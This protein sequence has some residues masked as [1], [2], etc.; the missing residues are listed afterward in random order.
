MTEGMQIIAKN[1][2][3]ELRIT[4]GSGF[5]RYYTWNGVTRSQIL[6]PR[7]KRWAGRFGIGFS[8]E[9]MWDNHQTI[10]SANLE[11]T[12][13]HFDNIS[14]TMLF[15]NHP[16]R[17][18]G[19]TV[20]SDEGLVVTW[21]KVLN[22]LKKKGNVLLVEVIQIY[23]DGKKPVVLPGSQNDCITVHRKN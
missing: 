14:D 1:K 21:K 11:E 18:D 22:P 8:K 15:L 17:K 20:Y 4:A 2:A 19:Y 23:V 10:T 13:L 16:G 5:K 12:Q 6:K 3:G 7:H 9:N